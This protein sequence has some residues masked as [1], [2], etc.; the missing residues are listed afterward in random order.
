[1]NISLWF[2]SDNFA[3][4]RKY[5]Y[6]KNFKRFNLNLIPKKISYSEKIFLEP[7]FKPTFAI[8]LFEI[9]GNLYLFKMSSKI[10]KLSHPHLFAFHSRSNVTF[11]IISWAR[12]FFNFWNRKWFEYFASK[13]FFTKSCQVNFRFVLSFVSCTKVNF[14]VKSPIS[15]SD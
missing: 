3:F 5:F 11:E 7:I 12:F 10:A 14:P 2:R 1:M 8:E 13:V 15:M 4:T 6:N 9:Q